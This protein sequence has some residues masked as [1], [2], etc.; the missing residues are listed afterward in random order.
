MLYVTD[1]FNQWFTEHTLVGKKV[2][3]FSSEMM[4]VTPWITLV[5]E[6]GS[7]VV[8]KW[9][10]LGYRYVARYY[11]VWNETA[12]TMEYAPLDSER[13]IGAKDVADLRLE[14]VI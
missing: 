12:Q 7:T 9:P 13:F 3:L 6:G 2:S 10:S 4:Q 1:A 5:F 11:V 8:A 14:M